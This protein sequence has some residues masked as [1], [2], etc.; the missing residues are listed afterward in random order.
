MRV[1]TR[2]AAGF[3]ALALIIGVAAFAWQETQP[4]TNADGI[5]TA[6]VRSGDVSVEVHAIAEVR[7]SR[8]ALLS[9]PGIPG[10]LQIVS[11][12]AT[13]ARVR[14]GEPVLRFDPAEQE[15]QLAQSRSELAQA[16]E[17]LRKAEDDAEVK[18]A[19]HA[20]D[21]MKARFAVRRAELDL[22]SNELVG[23][24][25]VEKNQL[26]LEEAK[27]RLEQLEG[28][29]NTLTADARASRAAIEEKR[30]KARLD[31]EGAQRNI[32]RMTLIAPFDGIVIAQENR[33]AN[34]GISFFGVS[35]PEYRTGDVV[36]SGRTVAEIFDSGAVDVIARIAEA[37][38]ANVTPGQKARVQFHPDPRRPLDATVAS[39][40]GS[41]PRRFWEANTRQLE[42]ML[43][44]IGN[45]AGLQP[46]WSGTVTIRGDAVRNATHVPRQALI[47]KDG[48]SLVYVQQ[49][50]GFVIRPVKVRRR[51]ETVA[52]V[53]GVPAGEIV[54][55]RNPETARAPAPAAGAMAAP[56]V[57]PR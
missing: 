9:A 40:G 2:A 50:N 29:T 6:V 45:A 26:A 49:G 55:L 7:A 21:V 27:R 47:E 33:D 20:I 54:A 43:R 38:A 51:T 18:Q 13:G 37:D 56:G 42:V 4:A 12:A 3:V 15:Y 53:E 5:P 10:T 11:M 57:A 14:R 17:E 25:Q 35:M 46:G 30:N 32:E 36:Q 31:V 48:R 41:G 28:D 34:G 23:K 8:A 52:V 39:V 22:R 16:E 1:R 44:V 19:Q 24:I